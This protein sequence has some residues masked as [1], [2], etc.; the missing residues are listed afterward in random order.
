MRGDACLCLPDVLGNSGVV[1]NLLGGILQI[2]HIEVACGVV[3]HGLESDVVCLVGIHGL[4]QQDAS[5]TDVRLAHHVRATRSSGCV[6]LATLHEAVV[7]QAL[8]DFGV[9]VVIVAVLSITDIVG[10]GSGRGVSAVGSLA[11]VHGDTHSSQ[12]VG[13]FTPVELY[14]STHVTTAL[15]G[16]SQLIGSAL[17]YGWETHGAVGHTTDTHLVTLHV[18]PAVAATGPVQEVG[19]LG[20]A[21]IVEV[22]VCTVG[23]DIYALVT[24]VGNLRAAD[25]VGHKLRP[26]GTHIPTDA[27]CL[28]VVACVVAI[29]EQLV[30]GVDDTVAHVEV[31]LQVGSATLMPSFSA[32]QLAS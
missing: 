1:I 29:G 12:V 14:H 13:V 30:D 2:V 20:D 4:A 31:A 27:V 18:R 16:I 22:L 6:L 7:A 5:D 26:H 15:D 10:N 17:R 32:S 28:H 24:L 19:L 11:H 3:H 25:A 9:I 23:G 8:V 21:H